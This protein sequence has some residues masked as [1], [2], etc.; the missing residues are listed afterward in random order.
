MGIPKI[1]V[2]RARSR[3]AHALSVIRPC[4]SLDQIASLQ[5]RSVNFSNTFL[6]TNCYLS[7]YEASVWSI[8]R[9]ILHGQFNRGYY[10]SDFSLVG[11]FGSIA[12]WDA[13]VARVPKGLREEGCPE[14]PRSKTSGA[15]HLLAAEST[16]ATAQ[17]DQMVHKGS[18]TARPNKKTL[19]AVF[20]KLPN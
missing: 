14:T 11:F 7:P 13:Y 16:M 8:P 9:A 4:L 12:L 17:S 10:H 2:P 19:S 20:V 5:K 18:M 6:T 15:F 1:R 3:L